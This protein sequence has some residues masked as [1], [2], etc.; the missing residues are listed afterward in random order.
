MTYG[1][2]PTGFV[3]PSLQ[4]ILEA[5]ERDQ[6]ALISEGLD[7]SPESPLGQING[8]KAR[9]L[10]M[11]WEALETAYNGFDPD[12]AEDF[13]LTAL[14]K[15]TGTF[16]GAAAKSTVLCSVTLT[17]GTTLIAGESYARVL[18]K[19]NVRFTPRE[20]FTA[21]TTATHHNVLFEAEIP[22]PVEVAAGQLSVIA[23]STVGW[24]AVTNPDQAKVGTVAANDPTF[25]TKRDEDL[26]RAG[27]QTVAAIKADLRALRH[28]G[29]QWIPSVEVFE[30]TSNV[31]DGEGRPAHSYE[32]L[33][34][35]LD[36]DA[37]TDADDQIAQVIWNNRPSGIEPWGQGVHSGEALN[38]KGEIVVMP[39]SRVILV[40]IYIS[41][42]LTTVPAFADQTKVKDEMVT[43]SRVAFAEPGSD[44]VAL[45]VRSLAFNVAGVVDVP[46]FTIGTTPSPVGTTNIAIGLRQ[47]PTF[48]AD[49]I[50]IT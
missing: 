43:K 3:R 10:S 38:E 23:T 5:I 7:Q 11:A 44:V 45:Y 4:E 27:N 35:D 15:L 26:A 25:R 30:N 6:R 42:T 31:P 21:P 33:V 9:Q 50:V 24:T 46:V 47:V 17:A 16:R 19:P 1:V 49:R 20:N 22:G 32:V 29:V 18:G 39:F 41:A 14:G 13:L 12:R 2:T 28:N 40:P 48:S 34:Y 36:A 37:P 8:I